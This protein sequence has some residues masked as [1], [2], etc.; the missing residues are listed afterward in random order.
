[1]ALASDAWLTSKKMP[2][3]ERIPF[4]ARLALCTFASSPS[5]SRACAA[6]CDDSRAIPLPYPVGDASGQIAGI[7]K[8]LQVHSGAAAV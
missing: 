3:S 1:M 2:V 6:A 8:L 4:A 7:Q 5:S